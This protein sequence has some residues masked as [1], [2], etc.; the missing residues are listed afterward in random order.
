MV[1]AI[2]HPT[3]TSCDE[4]NHPGLWILRLGRLSLQ[5]LTRCRAAL[6]FS[7]QNWLGESEDS[8][9]KAATSGIFSVGMSGKSSHPFDLNFYRGLW[10]IQSTGRH[11]NTHSLT[12]MPP[13]PGTGRE[14]HANVHS[15]CR[16]EQG[17]IIDLRRS[18][19]CSNMDGGI[20]CV[21]RMSMFS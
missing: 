5:K 11:W 1:G 20:Y 19:R 10:M 4:P 6:V 17:R 8:K 12:L 2:H 9:K 15:S 14:L 16:Q 3:S 18:R 21:G 13:S 7:V